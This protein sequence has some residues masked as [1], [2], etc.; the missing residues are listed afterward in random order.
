MRLVLSRTLDT[1]KVTPLDASDVA[2]ELRTVLVGYS[3]SLWIWD[4]EREEFKLCKDAPETIVVNGY[5]AAA[6]SS[7]FNRFLTIGTL[8]RRLQAV[9]EQL[10]G[11]VYRIISD[12]R[13]DEEQ[14]NRV[15]DACVLPRAHPRPFAHPQH[16]RG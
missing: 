15:L 11:Y 16:P 12:D 5:T 3:G 2:T 1:P 6:C 4:G 9:P 7:I 14:S 10:R 13:A 8:L